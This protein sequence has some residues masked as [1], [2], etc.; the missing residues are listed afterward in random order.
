MKINFRASLVVV[1]MLWAPVWAERENSVSASLDAVTA[2]DNNPQVSGLSFNQLNQGYLF[3]WGL[4]PNISLNSRGARSEFDLSY[5]FGLYRVEN[6]SL[7]LDSES[8]SAALGWKLNTERLTATFRES[9]KKSPDFAS[10]NLFQGIVFTPEGIFFDYNLVSLKRDSYWNTANLNLDYRFGARS[11]LVLG[12]GHTLRRFVDNPLFQRRIPNQQQATAN[13]GYARDLS[14]QTSLTTD[15][16]FS[17]FNYD[18][19]V[20]RDGTNQDVAL[21]FT[22]RFSPTVRMAVSGG[23]SYAQLVG[24]GGFNYWGYNASANVSK[25]FERESI[26]FYYRRDNSASTGIGGISKTHRLGFGF[27]QQFNRVIS[28]S[29]GLSAYTT[30]RVF[31]NVIDLRGLT[32]SLAF[33]FMLQR[34]IFLNVGA[35]YNSQKE[36]EQPSRTRTERPLQPRPQPRLRFAAV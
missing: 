2:A 33:N 15:Y 30:K 35:N 14:A 9:F 36:T 29:L 5:G 12:G 19:D 4:Y 7:N 34:H 10:F 17:Y 22:H 16:R 18:S 13:A 32:G 20:Y 6:T 24:G 3:T 1:L 28:A 25:S 21:G 27:S 8:H 31:D 23:P 26:N 11:H